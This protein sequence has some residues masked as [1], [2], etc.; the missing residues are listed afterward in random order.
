M[1]TLEARGSSLSIPRYKWTLLASSVGR[2]S[3]ILVFRSTFLFADVNGSGVDDV[4]VV[5][6]GGG[7]AYVD[8]LD[9]KKSGLLTDIL[10]ESG[11]RTHITY[12][13][14]VELERRARVDLDGAW[15]SSTP[16]VTYVVT[17]MTTSDSLPTPSNYQ[18]LYKYWDPVFDGGIVLFLDLLVFAQRVWEIRT[19]P[20]PMS[21]QHIFMKRA[22]RPDI[23]IALRV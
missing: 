5:N 14:T 1:S 4:V 18:I 7:M 15:R 17:S 21:K 16:Q 22:V 23:Q 2:P 19:I 20:H 3:M 6:A 12:A 8:L 13:T 10:T 9:G 11:V